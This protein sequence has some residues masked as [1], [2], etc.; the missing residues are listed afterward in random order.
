MSRT[1]WF[2]RYTLYVYAVVLSLYAFRKI[3]GRWVWMKAY[4][5]R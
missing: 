4:G 2:I 1:V 5:I 3:L